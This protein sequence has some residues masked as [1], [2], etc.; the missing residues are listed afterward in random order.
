[1]KAAVQHK[2]VIIAKQSNLVSFASNTKWPNHNSSTATSPE[3]KKSNSQIW[4]EYYVRVRQRDAE[5]QMQH[6]ISKAVKQL[7]IAR[8]QT[9]RA[10]GKQE[11][12]KQTSPKNF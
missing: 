8:R 4:S 9:Y 6:I 5:F 7:L 11:E 1:M 10:E 2:A 3:L 12:T